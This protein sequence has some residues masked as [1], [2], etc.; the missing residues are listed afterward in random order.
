VDEATLL[1]AY[2]AFNEACRVRTLRLVSLVMMTVDRERGALAITLDA[3][4][5]EASA[6]AQAIEAWSA[7]VAPVG[8]LV[9]FDPN[10][11]VFV[12]LNH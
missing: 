6:E 9:Q 2:E 11:G 4:K 3:S 12:P 10:P 5:P 1:E 7:E 8:V